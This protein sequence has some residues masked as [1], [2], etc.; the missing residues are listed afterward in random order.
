E[1][2]VED[3]R[4]V[5]RA[6]AAGPVGDERDVEVGLGRR[7]IQPLEEGAVIR[8]EKR[9]GGVEGEVLD[10]NRDLVVLHPGR[11]AERGCRT[12][13]DA[14]DLVAGAAAQQVEAPRSGVDVGGG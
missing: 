4:D 14:A 7:M 12:G 2:G 9:T 8:V 10:R 6:T 11:V 5:A 3:R 13:K 1:L